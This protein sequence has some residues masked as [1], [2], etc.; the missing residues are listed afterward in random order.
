MI[1][2]RTASR[3][4]SCDADILEHAEGCARKRTAVGK[5]LDVLR[6]WLIRLPDHGAAARPDVPEEFYRFPCF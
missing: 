2:M 5:A 6:L 4:W 3:P 1:M